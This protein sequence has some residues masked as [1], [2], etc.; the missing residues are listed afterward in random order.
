[1]MKISFDFDDCLSEEWIQQ[2]AKTLS[3]EHEIWIVTSRSKLA[4]DLLEVATNLCIP[5]ERIVLTDGAMKWSSLNHYCIDV[6]YDDMWDEI[7]EINCR[8]KCKGILIG[9]DNVEFI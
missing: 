1:M 8:K 4:I 2:L 6:H 7:M 5:T 9:F 3:L